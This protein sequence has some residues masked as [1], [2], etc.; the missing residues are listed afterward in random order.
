MTDVDNSSDAQAKIESRPRRKRRLTNAERANHTRRLILETTVEAL[1][2]HGYGAASTHFVAQMAGISRG[3]MQHHFQSKAQ[4]MTAVM[5][6]CYYA[7]ADYREAELAKLPNGL[8][9]YR[10]LIPMAWETAQMAEGMAVNEIRIASRSDPVLAESV[11]PVA[12]KIA[13]HY[14]RFCGRQV[15]EAG[16]KSNDEIR[17]LS[18]TWAMALRAL[19]IDR[20][21]HPDDLTVRIVLG[22]MMA[23]QDKLIVE[24]LGPDALKAAGPARPWS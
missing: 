6:Y 13:A 14:G 5:E 1:R 9:R 19:A 8:A 12:I 17:G 16:L 18:A 24:Q 7:Q 4:L 2:T 3:A 15:R 23:M 20:A 11:I 10:A 22:A 21:T